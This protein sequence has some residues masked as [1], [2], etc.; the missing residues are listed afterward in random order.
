MVRIY[1]FLNYN[2]AGGGGGGALGF[3][4]IILVLRIL[5]FKSTICCIYINYIQ[6]IP[7]LG[8]HPIRM[9][10]VLVHHTWFSSMFGN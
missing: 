7:H 2:L 3:D 6:F 1:A 4:C 9:G 10:M 8:F 5:K